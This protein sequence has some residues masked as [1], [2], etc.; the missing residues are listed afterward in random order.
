MR[1]V[2]RT[3]V[4]GV[5]FRCRTSQLWQIFGA[6]RKPRRPV[7][8]SPGSNG[9]ELA[10]IRGPPARVHPLRSERGGRVLAPAG[11]EAA[12]AGAVEFAEFF[13]RR[14]AATLGDSSVAGAEAHGPHVEGDERRV[15][16]AREFGVWPEVFADLAALLHE[17][18]GAA[19]APGRP[20]LSGIRRLGIRRIFFPVVR[21]MAVP[22]T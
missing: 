13:E 8:R 18:K 6:R 20:N 9:A 2:I 21:R 14:D 22:S 15:A 1:V 12:P 11:N 3:L 10:A 4:G 7:E 5:S 19:G 17:A 16:V